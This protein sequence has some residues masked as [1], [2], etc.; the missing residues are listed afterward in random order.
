MKPLPIILLSNVKDHYNLIDALY[1]M[2]YKYSRHVSKEHNLVRYKEDIQIMEDTC[3][4][5]YLAIISIDDEMSATA[6][7]FPIKDY[8]DIPFTYMNSPAQ[9]LSYAKTLKP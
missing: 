2:G 7:S 8:Q 1:D 4:Y 9:F 5:K 3:R 6:F